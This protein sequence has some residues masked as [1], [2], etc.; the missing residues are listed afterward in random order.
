MEKRSDKK[1]EIF[2]GFLILWVILSVAIL[3]NRLVEAAKAEGNTISLLQ[4]TGTSANNEEQIWETTTEIEVFR[5]AYQNDSK[6]IS[7][8]SS[9]EDKVIAPGTNQE[10][11]FKIKNNS[12]ETMSY[13]MTCEVFTEP[14]DLFFPVE[15]SLKSYSGSYLLGDED[16]L[17]N[18]ED[19]SLIT[20]LADLAGNHYAFYTLN[21]QWPFEWGNDEYDTYLGNRA[22]EEDLKV[23]VVIKTIAEMD[24]ERN[25]EPKTGDGAKIKLWLGIAGLCLLIIIVLYFKRKK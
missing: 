5:A 23:T 18:V 1:K 7:V 6:E 25:G 9:N 17:V 14:K 20:D 19:I 3:G 22:V 12:D 4:T 8:L 21:W 11:T 2:I 24:T 13:K 15:M 16:T 10:Y